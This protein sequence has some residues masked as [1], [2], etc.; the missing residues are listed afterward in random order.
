MNFETSVLNARTLHGTLQ[1]ANV[2]G[3]PHEPGEGIKDHGRGK[4]RRYRGDCND[5]TI[6]Q[7]MNY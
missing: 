3:P 5:N 6:N 7:Y 1:D 4:R 2:L